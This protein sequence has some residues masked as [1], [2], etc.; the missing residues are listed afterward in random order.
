[1]VDIGANGRISDDAVIVNIKF[2]QALENETLTLPA[3]NMLAS[4]N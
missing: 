3:A 1:M 4:I 2:G